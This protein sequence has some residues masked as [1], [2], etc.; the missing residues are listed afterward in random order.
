MQKSTCYRLIR[1]NTTGASEYLLTPSYL[2]IMKDPAGKE[3]Y[4]HF[5]KVQVAP[6]IFKWSCTEE[7]TGLK[8]ID[9]DTS[10]KQEALERMK[11]IVPVLNHVLSKH[12]HYIEKMRAFKE[13][14]K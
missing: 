4:I 7:S 10:T 12:T 1:N 2:E 14:L 8:C 5:H 9:R 11:E 13:S 3:F 6:K